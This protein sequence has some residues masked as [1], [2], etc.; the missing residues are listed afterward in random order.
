M[1]LHEQLAHI[2]KEANINQSTLAKS[3]GVSQ[4]RIS[5]Y[6]SGKREITIPT[7][8]KWAEICGY[9]FNIQFTKKAR[10]I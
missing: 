2:R 9:D 10:M 7:I 3:L 1:Q 5:E 8:R 6:E 4:A